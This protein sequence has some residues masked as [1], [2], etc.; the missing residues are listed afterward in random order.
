MRVIHASNDTGTFEA[1]IFLDDDETDNVMGL[2]EGTPATRI[3]F[4]ELVQ[5]PPGF[6][7]ATWDVYIKDRP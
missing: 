1:V 6:S 3:D 7:P 2:L 5:F 4:D